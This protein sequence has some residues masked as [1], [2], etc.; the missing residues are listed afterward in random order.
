[1]CSLVPVLN[2]LNWSRSSKSY[3]ISSPNWLGTFW[4]LIG[5]VAYILNT[6][7]WMSNLTSWLDKVCYAVVM[8]VFRKLKY[9][10]FFSYP[11]LIMKRSSTRG[12]SLIIIFLFLMFS[13]KAPNLKIIFA[14]RKYRPRRMA[15][16]LFIWTQYIINHKLLLVFG[17]NSEIVLMLVIRITQM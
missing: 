5:H 16:S 10:D 2:I 9:L 15:T 14:F 8:I 4:P 3:F 11:S 6:P 1:M 17:V 7:N 13:A 12:V